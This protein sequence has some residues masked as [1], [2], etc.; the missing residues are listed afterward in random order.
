MRDI[1]RYFDEQ[2]ANMRAGLARG[3][4][5]PRATLAGR[6]ASIATFADRNVVENPFYAAFK[7]MPSIIPAR[8][9]QALRDEGVAAIKQQVVPAYEKLLAF[10][11]NEYVPR[12]RTT[13]SAHD[14]PD[15][16]AFYRS[17][18]R[19]YTTTSWARR[20]STSSASRRS[21]GSTPRCARRWRRAAS[22]AHSTISSN[23]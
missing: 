15:G 19:E 6:D 5:V 21:R 20:R 14:L 1:P 18:I 10:F 2:I 4:S 16:D 9:Q 12:A 13:V 17:Q 11:R 7:N 3:F 8:E 23:S 22:K